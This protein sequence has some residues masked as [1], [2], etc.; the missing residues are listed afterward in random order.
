MGRRLSAPNTVLALLCAMYLVLYIDR[1]NIATAAPFIQRDLDLSN[2]ELGL[3][4][5][6]FAY[7]YTVFQLIGGWLG[8]RFGARRTLCVS[9]ILVCIATALTGM[10]G[11]LAT[12][13]LARVALGLGEGSALPTATHAM[14][15]WTPAGRWG[16]AQGITHSSA[17]FG[18]W[19]TPP[20]VAALIV[21]FSWRDSFFILAGISLVW[22]AIWAW[23]FRDSP[24]DHPHVT[25]D[26]L[27]RLPS[28]R[29]ADGARAVPWLRLFRRI[30]PATAVDFFYG[31]A[32]W[33]FLTWIPSFFVQNFQLD[34][35]SSALFS[36]GVFFGGVVGDTL[37]GWVSDYVL[38]RTGNI[39]AARRN[40]IVV[41]FVGAAAC[42][43]PVIFVHDLTLSVICLSA[44]FFF[45]ELI[46]APVWAVPMDIAPRYAGTAA[47][48]MNFGSA[49][50]GIVSPVVFGYLVDI[51]GSWTVPFI[52]VV[53]LLLFGVVPAFYM[54]PD[55]PFDDAEERAAEGILKPAE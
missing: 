51:S 41:G 26:D 10:V 39:D 12:L 46:V 48:M 49:F 37:G 24:N 5:S 21:S 35:R 43:L 4:L 27:A 50:A 38:K 47:G 31:W 2:T 53:V 36:S 28:K 44:A 45:A 14:S 40:V 25:S 32:L 52:A 55:L 30:F 8:N 16:F 42:F 7:P 34:I 17:R 20:I 23:Y 19:I 54:R 15:S 33:L 11:G 1:V 29:P 9:L 6:A 13:F 18:N 3:A 22:T